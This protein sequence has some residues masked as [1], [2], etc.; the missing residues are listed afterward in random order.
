MKSPETLFVK[1]CQTATAVVVVIMGTL[2]IDISW[3]LCILA[4]WV[5]VGVKQS[6]DDIEQEDIAAAQAAG[7]EA[8]DSSLPPGGS[9]RDRPPGGPSGN[10]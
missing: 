10:A 4:L 6:F 2:G 7:L 5:Y 8:A 1:G 3:V 9:T